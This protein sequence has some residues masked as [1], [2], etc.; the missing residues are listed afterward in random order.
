MIE[1]ARS[2]SGADLALFGLTEGALLAFASTRPGTP[3]FVLVALDAAALL[4]RLRPMRREP[5]LLV[6]RI[7]WGMLVLTAIVTLG[8]TMFPL[9]PAFVATLLPKVLGWGFAVLCVVFVAGRRQWKPLRAA[10]PAGVGL[11]VIAAL[12]PGVALPFPLALAAASVVVGLAIAGGRGF[13]RRLLRIAFAS[14]VA[15]SLAVAIS[16]FLPW[17]QPTSSRPRPA[18]SPAPPPSP[19]SPS[20]RAWATPL[21]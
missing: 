13:P 3:V 11:F 8:A 19:A 21:S 10:G 16:R 5:A 17:A 15:A 12:H 9:L 4:V 1:R 2:W 20:T 14:L 7:S 18:S 6:E